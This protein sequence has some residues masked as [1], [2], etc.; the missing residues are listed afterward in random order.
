MGRTLGSKPVR[1]VHEIRLKDRFNNQQHCRLDYSVPYCRYAQRAFTTIW[2]G[3]PHTTHRHRPV[4]LS[5]EALLNFIQ[6]S[7]NAAGTTFNIIES[8]T[9]DAGCTFVGPSNLIGTAQHISPIDTIIQHV[10]SELR[11]QLRL[12]VKLLSQSSEFCWQPD[13][14][15]VSTLPHI[16]RSPDC[17]L[18]RSGTI[19]QAVHSLSDSAY[20]QQGPLA[21]SC[22]QGFLA[23]MGLS[24]SRLQQSLRLF[25]PGYPPALSPGRNG[26]PRFLGAS[27]RARS[28]LSP[29]GALQVRL[30]V[31]SLQVTGFIISGSLATP[32][33]CNE[34]ETGSLALGLTRLRSRGFAPLASTYFYGHRPA[35]CARLPSRRGPPLH[36]ERTIS[37]ADSFQSA[38]CTRLRL[39][40][41]SHTLLPPLPVLIPSFS[42]KCKKGEIA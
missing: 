22:F 10:K 23:T 34:A 11:L 6:K 18:F 30:S 4:C 26:S 27:F 20:P 21:P 37:M 16:N 41:Q 35:S 15:D 25:I 29:R 24:D 3:Y 8:N 40:L 2:F 5:S 39:A 19:V 32:D 38:R 7:F 1:T 31:S 13:F 9:V 36:G 12:P 14:L 28:P 17:Q 42:Q 33:K